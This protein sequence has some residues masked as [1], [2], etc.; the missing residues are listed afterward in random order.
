MELSTTAQTAHLLG[1]YQ[2][3]KT[4]DVHLFELLIYVS[5]KDVDVSAFTQK[6]DMLPKDSW[7]VAY[8]ES[9]LNSDGTEVIGTFLNQDSLPG[10]ETRIAFFMYFVDFDKPLSS[11][12]GDI[13]LSPPSHV[14]E[15]LLKIIEFEPVD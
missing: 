8:D 1:V 5:P 13:V 10:V 6:H 12:Y 2:I 15:R 3:D 9:F 7:Q 11:Q 14:P 4:P